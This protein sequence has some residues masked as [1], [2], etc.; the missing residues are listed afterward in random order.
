MPPWITQFALHHPLLIYALIVVFACAEGPILS[1][2]FGILWRLG[3]VPVV[4]VYAAL[5]L[6]D[7]LGDIIW[8]HV[9]RRFGHG[10]VARFG[11]YFDVTEDKVERMAALFHRHKHLVLFVSK[12]SNGAGFAL[13]TL[14]TAGMVRIPFGI[15][16]TVNLLGQFLWTGTLLF[17]G[18][19]FS[20]AYLHINSLM[21]HLSLI[22][23]G[24]LLTVAVV[25]FLGYLR[26]KADHLP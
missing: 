1:V 11:K 10:F 22:A 2:A 7:L 14:V 18:Y 25:R 26:R 19:T 8:Y 21:G 20:N 17:I 24:L 12:I 23:A 13:V 9:G 5:M 3:C 16:I 4:P 15:Y 6:G